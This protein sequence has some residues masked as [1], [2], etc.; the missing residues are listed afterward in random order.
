MWC[1]MWLKVHDLIVSDIKEGNV[2]NNINTPIVSGLGIAFRSLYDARVYKGEY[3]SVEL[4]KLVQ[5]KGVFC[6]F[7][8]F[9]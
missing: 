2:I 6:T 4:K 3:S 5:S 9:Y 1:R 8:K 7:L